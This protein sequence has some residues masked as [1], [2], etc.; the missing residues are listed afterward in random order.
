MND[1][2]RTQLRREK[3]GTQCYEYYLKIDTR[4]LEKLW[5]RELKWVG[6]CELALKTMEERC[7]LYRIGE[8]YRIL[9][10]WP[11]LFCGEMLKRFAQ[12]TINHLAT[13]YARYVS[14]YK[15]ESS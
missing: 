13:E 2:K 8:D 4:K 14:V 12:L 1:A 11:Y 10:R 7:F 3:I 6:Q 9:L 5:N 15:R